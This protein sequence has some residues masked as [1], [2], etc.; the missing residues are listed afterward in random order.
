MTPLASGPHVPFAVPFKTDHATFVLGPYDY[1]EYKYH[2]AQGATLLYA[3]EATTTVI[4]DFHGAAEGPH[5]GA[6]ISVDKSSAPRGSGSLAAPFSGMHGWYWENPGGSTVTVTIT[7]AG[8]YSTAIEYRS[9]R[10]RIVHDL[11]TGASAAR[12][13]ASK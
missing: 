11:N 5:A 3:W 1:V 7:T 2:L 4:Q 13:G 12:P 8:Y 10:T 9:D 6:E